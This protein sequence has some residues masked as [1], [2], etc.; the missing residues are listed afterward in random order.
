M[1]Y[2]NIIYYYWYISQIIIYFLYFCIGLYIIGFVKN[3]KATYYLNI[4][5][6]YTKLIVSLF[7]IYKFNM[8]QTNIKF[9]EID[10][11]M[12]FQVGLFL[13]LTLIYNNLLIYYINDIKLNIRNRKLYFL[14]EL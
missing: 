10:R 2:E 11:R 8:F 9:T 3:D 4:V 5:D 13:F 6:S 12:V 1:K 14:F 7:L